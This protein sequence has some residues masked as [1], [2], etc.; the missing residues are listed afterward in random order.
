MENIGNKKDIPY[1]EEVVK[2]YIERLFTIEQEVRTLRLDKKEL[3]EEFKSKVD[4]KL[5][6]SVIR[7][8]KSQFKLTAS[9]ETVQDLVNLVKEKINMVID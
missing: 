7:L 3:K 9:E 6:S 5:V 8:V 1:D 2:E 4:M